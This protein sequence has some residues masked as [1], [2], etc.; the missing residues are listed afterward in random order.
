MDIWGLAL[1]NLVVDWAPFRGSGRTWGHRDTSL[2]RNLCDLG[3]LMRELSKEDLE[4][5]DLSPT[6]IAGRGVRTYHRLLCVRRKMRTLWEM[7]RPFPFQA[8]GISL[9]AQLQGVSVMLPFVHNRL[10]HTCNLQPRC[11]VLRRERKSKL[12]GIVTQLL[13][14]LQLQV[15][16]SLLAPEK[17]WWW[18]GRIGC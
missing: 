1:W 17:C 4:G 13:H 10:V 18:R 7:T 16:P 12:F 5:L 2:P 6:F 8:L 3:Y 14:I 15:N 9:K 11:I